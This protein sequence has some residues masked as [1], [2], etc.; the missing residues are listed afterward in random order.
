[1]QPP[2]PQNLQSGPSPT[3][4]AGPRVSEP[5]AAT[6]PD[7]AGQPAHSQARGL[8]RNSAGWR[9]LWARQAL[10][11]PRAHSKRR[12]AR[13]GRP[14]SSG[15]LWTTVLPVS[16]TLPITQLFSCSVEFFLPSCLPCPVFLS[17]GVLSSLQQNAGTDLPP[18]RSSPAPKTACPLVSRS[19]QWVPVCCVT[20][21]MIFLLYIVFLLGFFILSI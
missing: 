10:F 15:P 6:L 4:K 17:F 2:L 18:V 13:I 1:M 3:A 11:Q 21:S 20:I 8:T 7:S 9:S 19:C 16:S 14:A 12:K 5:A